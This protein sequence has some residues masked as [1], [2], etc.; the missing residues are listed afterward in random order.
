MRAKYLLPCTCGREIPVEATQAG[1]PIRCQCGLELEVPTL[2]NLTRL[3]PAEPPAAAPRRAR[4]AWGRRQRVMLAGLAIM[5]I[6]ALW[7]GWELL[8]RPHPLEVASFRPAWAVLYWTSLKRGVE[9]R[10]PFE[11]NYT[12]WLDDN[13][14]WLAVAGVVTGLGLLTVGLSPLISNRRKAGG[15][16][17]PVPG[18]RMPGPGAQRAG[19]PKK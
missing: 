4:S 6:G 5:A 12:T 10:M 17:R 13:N 1:Q 7:T 3:K 8:Q 18:K 9:Y 11:V 14:R 2:R 16:S 15:V 19:P